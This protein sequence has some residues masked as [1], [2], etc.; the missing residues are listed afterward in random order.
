MEVISILLLLV[1]IMLWLLIEQY[2]ILLEVTCD[3]TG[4]AS[5]CRFMQERCYVNSGILTQEQILNSNHYY[6]NNLYME[7]VSKLTTVN[8]LDNIYYMDIM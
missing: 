3:L 4:S 1:Y 2:S 7:C 8:S 5:F 6:S